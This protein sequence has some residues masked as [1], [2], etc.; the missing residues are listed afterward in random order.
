[1]EATEWNENWEHFWIEEEKLLQ[2]SNNSSSSV[3]KEN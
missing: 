1:M 2:Y 3:E